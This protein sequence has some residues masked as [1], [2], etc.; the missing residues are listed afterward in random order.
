MIIGIDPGL[1]GAIALVNDGDIVLLWDMPV[2]EKTYGRGK[3]VDA[4]GLADCVREAANTA[5]Y[6]YTKTLTAH[7]ER[8]SSMPKE[9][10]TS[11]FSFGH[12][13]GVIDGVLGALLIPVVYMTPQKWKQHHG[14]IGKPKDASR[15]LVIQQYPHRLD[16][17]AR[18]KDVGRA[19]AVLIATA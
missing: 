14:L 17:F 11:A 19:D 2:A 6:Q 7:V 15:T 12:S 16:K 1:T 9:G 4:Y 10:V 8:V 13:T 5:I 3:Q 18:K